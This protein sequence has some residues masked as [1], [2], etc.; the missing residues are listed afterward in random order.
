[1]NKVDKISPMGTFCYNFNL[2]QYIL[3]LKNITL[4]H[5]IITLNSLKFPH[6]TYY[7]GSF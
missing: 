7:L 1:M 4:I 3:E 5:L 6:A 2:T